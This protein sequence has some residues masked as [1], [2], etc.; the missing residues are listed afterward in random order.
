MNDFGSVVLELVVVGGALGILGGSFLLPAQW[1]RL[2]GYAGVC[3]VL[4]SFLMSFMIS[5]PSRGAL[6]G[7]TYLVDGLGLFFK[8]LFLVA[9]GLVLLG[10]CESAAASP[11]SGVEFT[12]LLLV[13]LAGMMFAASAGNCVLLFVALEVVTAA[14]YVL[15][16]LEGNNESVLEA[17]VKFLVTGAIASAFLVLG[18]AFVYS[19]TGNMDFDKLDPGMVLVGNKRLFQLGLVLVFVG[20]GFKLGAIPSQMW[21]PDVYQG[22]QPS[23]TAFLA[24]GSKA[25]GLVLLIRIV[26]ATANGAARVWDVLLLFSAAASILYGAL[27]AVPQRNL[28]RLLGYS[29]IVTAGYLTVGVACG[30]RQGTAAA[31][32][33]MT[34]YTLAVI[35]AFTV[36]S[37]VV[38][39]SETAEM[40]VFAGLYKRSPLLALT[41]TL[42]MISLAGIPPLA[43]FFGK[44]VLL[45][46]G[47]EAAV[48][49]PTLMVLL[50]V[51]LTGIIISIYY[52]FSVIKAVY[53]V[54]PVE[55]AEQIWVAFPTKIALGIMITGLVWLGLFPNSILRVSSGAIAGA[56]GL[57]PALAGQ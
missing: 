2:S 10:A 25:A 43:G 33:Y 49:K 12:V 3:V 38:A 14:F 5:W 53:W 21:V 11:R 39:E 37:V 34:V 30:T 13:A 45:K 48:A 9:G 22:S 17:G 50:G 15:V 28:K 35:A 24:S 6:F 42:A 27:C 44:F 36:I 20:L 26:G 8:R 54:A 16:V 4:I 40:E 23:V 52:Y 46:A 7:G 31:M 55:K 51:M 1:K 56:V 19:V 32:Y 47:V 29:S 57:W 41:L 18:V